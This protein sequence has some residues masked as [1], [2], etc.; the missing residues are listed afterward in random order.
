MRGGVTV[1]KAASRS[2][3]WVLVAY[4]VLRKMSG[5]TSVSD[6]QPR[7]LHYPFGRCIG[8]G[9]ENRPLASRSERAKLARHANRILT[10]GWSIRSR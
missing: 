3:L 9:R 5:P 1:V 6:S 4:R 7:V 2:D 8:V 10:V